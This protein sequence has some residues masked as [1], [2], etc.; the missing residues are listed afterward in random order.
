MVWNVDEPV[1]LSYS[2]EYAL[3][4]FQF[5]LKYRSPFRVFQVVASAVGESHEVLVVLVSSSANY[6]VEGVNVESR[7]DVLQQVLWHTVV[8]DDTYRLAAFPAFYTPCHLLHY[9]TAE[10]VVHLHL[11]VLRKLK[12]IRFV[13]AVAASYENHGKTVSYHVVEEHDIFL[14]V[15]FW[16]SDEPSY[17][18][19]R[20]CNES[21]VCLRLFLPLN[22]FHS[23]Y[24]EEDAIVGSCTY[25]LYL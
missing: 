1:F 24:C 11:S 15:T 4:L 16:Q 14:F 3:C 23:L 13:S 7:H 5:R 10:V 2:V 19:V 18:F 21:I 12:R 22:P 6:G 17:F 8:V 20:H 25:F 9:A